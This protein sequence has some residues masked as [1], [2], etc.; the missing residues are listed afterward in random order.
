MVLETTPSTPPLGWYVIFFVG[1]KGTTTLGK[2]VRV[3]QNQ[4]ADLPLCVDGEWVVIKMEIHKVPAM[5]IPQST[6]KGSRVKRE[7]N[8]KQSWSDHE[9]YQVIQ[10]WDGIEL[11]VR[12]SKKKK[13][14]KSTPTPSTTTSTSDAASTTTASTTA[15]TTR[16]ST[17]TTT[18]MRFHTIYQL[19]G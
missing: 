6:V 18:S 4:I 5:E 10:D 19:L 9:Y 2:T 16:T 3:Y 1:E 12:V 17:T 15:R 11:T 14:H 13:S 7:T 8:I